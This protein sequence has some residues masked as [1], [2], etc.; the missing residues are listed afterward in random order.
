MRSIALL[1]LVLIGCG[2]EAAT[3]EPRVVSKEA[4]LRPTDTTS[5]LM[6]RYLGTDTV[7]STILAMLNAVN[8]IV[9]EKS[10]R[11]QSRVTPQDS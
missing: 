9:T 8:R 10:I 3:R 7:E 2:E 5:G 6:W 1:C 11:S 4:E